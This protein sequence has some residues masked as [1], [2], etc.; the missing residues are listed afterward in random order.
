MA[1]GEFL[2]GSEKNYYGAYVKRT[3]SGSTINWRTK[4]VYTSS[5]SPTTLTVTFALWFM[6]SGGSS[7]EIKIGP[8]S[9]C[10]AKLKVAGTQVKSVT[11]PSSG[12]SKTIH[13]DDDWKLLTWTTTYT[14]GTSA[15]SKSV[16]GSLTVSSASPWHGTS[17]ATTTITVPALASYAVKY[18]PNG[19]EGSITQQTK[20]YGKNLALSNGA[21]FSRQYYT[22]KEWNTAA[23]GTGTRYG[24]GA[25]YTG[26]APL[27]LYAQWVLNAVKTYAKVDD[28]IKS[29]ILYA[30]VDDSIV[31]VKSGYVK[32]DGEWKLIG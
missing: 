14:K 31:T 29:G 13:A 10:T 17:T 9:N 2:D 18:Y 32:V 27:D 8:S 30:K 21:G 22:L 15:V 28:S 7:T 1:S 11:L 20:Y 6:L 5:E 16:S 3:Y 25:T 26:N 23:A 19:G 4:L 24:I 12:N